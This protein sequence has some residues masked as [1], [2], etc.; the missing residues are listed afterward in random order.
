M[1]APPL[2]LFICHFSSP[3]RDLYRKNP[4]LHFK[5]EENSVV[6]SF[7]QIS[8]LEEVIMEKPTSP[9]GEDDKLQA[10]GRRQW[11]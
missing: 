9:L 6:T 4:L 7:L 11:G 3:R 2:S 1:A 10:K 5:D 8:T